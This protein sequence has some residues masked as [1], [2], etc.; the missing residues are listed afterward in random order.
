MEYSVDPTDPRL[1]HNILYI[2]AYKLL[3][4]GMRNYF[5]MLIY[6]L[7]N[8]HVSAACIKHKISENL[9]IPLHNCPW[10]LRRPAEKTGII[11]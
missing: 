3:C 11:T 9:L 10:H 4:H 2:M 8:I 7:L 5:L 1:A 6:I